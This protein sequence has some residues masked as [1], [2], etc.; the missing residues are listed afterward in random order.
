MATGLCRPRGIG[1]RHC[2]PSPCVYKDA[3][4]EVD[5]EAHFRGE[6][7]GPTIG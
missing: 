7:D 6:G 1:W 2:V 4:M 3:A 5:R